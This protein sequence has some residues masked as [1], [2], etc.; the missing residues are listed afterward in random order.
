[1]KCLSNPAPQSTGKPSL[2]GEGRKSEG[3]RGNGGHQVSK[4]TK[5]SVYVLTETEAEITGQL[6]VCNRSSVFM[7]SF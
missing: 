7:L 2:G 6:Q 3:A 4:S 5:K 1:M